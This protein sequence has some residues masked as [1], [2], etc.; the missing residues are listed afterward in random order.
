MSLEAILA[1]IEA[2]GDADAAR[3]RAETE[4]RVRQIQTEAERSASARHEQARR[5]ALLP[6]AGERARRLHRA[7]LE[8]LR[9][10]GEVCDRLVDAALAGTRASLA[11]IRASPDYPIILRRLTEEALTVLGDEAQPG[12]PP[13]L[14]ADPRDTALLRQVL[15]GIGLDAPITP[16]LNGWGGVVARSGDGRIVAINTLEARLERAAPFLRRQL[17]AL[18]ENECLT[19]TT[20]TPAFAQ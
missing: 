13:R 2:G 1:V 15:D 5:A 20:P 4:A 11:G 9:T 17:A 6:A 18:F 16:C 14:E 19:S 12:A 3:I 7:R 10:V 8:S